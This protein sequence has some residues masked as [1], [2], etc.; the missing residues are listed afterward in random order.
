MLSKVIPLHNFG[1]PFSSNDVKLGVVYELQHRKSA[2]G[3][4]GKETW[5][6]FSRPI[7]ERELNSIVEADSQVF[8]VLE[9]DE[10]HLQ[11]PLLHYCNKNQSNSSKNHIFE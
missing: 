6:V 8:K 2:K 3:A 9:F 7:L 5:G 10:I 1:S 11:Q 4:P